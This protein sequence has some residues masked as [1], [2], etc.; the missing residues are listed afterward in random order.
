MEHIKSQSGGHAASHPGHEKTD[1]NV[2]VILGFGVFLALMALVIHVGL[3]GMYRGMEKMADNAE[4][5]SKPMI[6]K[7]AASTEAEKKDKSGIAQMET[8]QEAIQRLN[9]TFPAP[10]LQP[11]EYTDLNT[12]KKNQEMHLTGYTWV[13][14]N[15]GIVQI[16]VSRAMEIIAERG[17][18]SVPATKGA[19]KAAQTPARK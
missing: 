13:D 17:L 2:P 15:A 5:A 19:A 8:Q 7:P 10:R 9:A 18:P 16:P 1:L 3:W 11:D 14:K 4:A 6:I 12:F